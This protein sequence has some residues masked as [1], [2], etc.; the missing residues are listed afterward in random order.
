MSAYICEDSIFSTLGAF[1]A[2]TVD[3]LSAQDAANILKHQNIKSVNCRY[4]ENE[5]LTSADLKTSIVD[6][7]RGA[8]LAMCSEYDYQACETDDYNESAAALLIDKIRSNAVAY[9]AN[10]G[11]TAGENGD[12][13]RA[14]YDS[15]YGRR[16][17]I[18]GEKETSE[19]SYMLDFSAG[20]MIK[21][22]STLLTVVWLPGEAGG[23][24][25][26]NSNNKNLLEQ[27]LTSP[28]NWPAITPAQAVALLNDCNNEEAARHKKLDEEREEAARRA[29]A[30]QDE[31]SRYIP[32]NCKGVIV[33]EFWQDDSDS[34]TDYFSRSTQKTLIIGFS[35]NNRNSFPEMRKAIKTADL[36]K[37]SEVLSLADPERSEECRENWS[38]GKGYYLQKQGASNYSGWKVK[39][40]R[41]YKGQLIEAK[42][43]PEGEIL[44]TLNKTENKTTAVN[45]AA[46]A[47]QLN[48][49]KQGVEIKFNGKPPATIREKLKAAGFRWSRR[50]GLWY[51]KQNAAR[52][53]F[54]NSLKSENAGGLA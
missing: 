49:E 31:I 44:L 10:D 7:D 25:R 22:S 11:T 35:S 28:H 50:A 9:V 45:D 17:Y 23:Q 27:E 6:A 51:A 3:G 43:I 1:A 13:G 12:I 41:A 34:M 37:Y 36:T 15:S 30:F 40:I 29:L 32:A 8:I 53:E 4:N 5:A 21:N 38:M 2:L 33:A 19:K 47:V 46:V 16:G 20:G 39:K 18:V 48:D 52:I 14:L 24:L 42:D 54:A 26:K